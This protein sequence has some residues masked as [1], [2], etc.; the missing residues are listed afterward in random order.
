MEAG[1]GA[2]FRKIE[3]QKLINELG[4]LGAPK[5]TKEW[6]ESAL[7]KLNEALVNGRV[8]EGSF[9]E[10]RQQVW[11]GILRMPRTTPQ[12]KQEVRRWLEQALRRRLIGTAEKEALE[13]EVGE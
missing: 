1:P 7:Q 3:T 2:A 8:S 10:L 13:R 6:A 9:N 12:E 4:Q 5:G 11:D